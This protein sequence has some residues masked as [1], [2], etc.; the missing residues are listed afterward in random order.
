MVRQSSSPE[1]EPDFSKLPP[2]GIEHQRSVRQTRA[3]PASLG[4][5]A[6][7][8]LSSLAL[9]ASSAQDLQGGN[10]SQGG[11]NQ[12]CLPLASPAVARMSP[13]SPRPLPNHPNI[14][15]GYPVLDEHV[16]SQ[17]HIPMHSLNELNSIAP[18]GRPRGTKFMRHVLARNRREEEETH[19]NKTVSER[20]TPDLPRRTDSSSNASSDARTQSSDSSKRRK[21]DA[22][23]AVFLEEVDLDSDEDE[24]LESE[25]AMVRILEQD[26][27]L[28][29]EV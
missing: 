20:T 4:N 2:V 7:D 24:C 8:E 11:S 3:E 27:S 12:Q 18:R 28:I 22:D 1:S 29:S 13:P 5:Q 17:D 19:Q 26:I 10:Q 23:L 25:E 6:M 21:V 15:I 9:L 16:F 14:S